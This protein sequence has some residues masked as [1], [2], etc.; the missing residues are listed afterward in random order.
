MA[1]TRQQRR[2][3]ARAEADGGKVTVM[4]R[5]SQGQRMPEKSNFTA[6]ETLE[7]QEMQRMVNARRVEAELVAGNT[8]LIPRGQEVAKEIDA[9]ARL[10]DNNKNQWFSQ[11]L[12]EHGYPQDSQVQI[13]LTTG[14]IVEV[15]PEP[16]VAKPKKKGKK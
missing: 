1:L 2:A 7:L 16:V 10:L 6:H 4:A 12:R 14:E 11:K 3:Q 13:N 5:E 8:A 9:L 15:K